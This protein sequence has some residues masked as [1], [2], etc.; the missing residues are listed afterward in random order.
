MRP[1]SLLGVIVRS[2]EALIY[3]LER[4]QNS[5]R[6]CYSWNRGKEHLRTFCERTSNTEIQRL[7]MVRNDRREGLR[8]NE[9]DIRF[10]RSTVSTEQGGTMG[11]RYA[12][13]RSHHRGV[14]GCCR[15]SRLI[16]RATLQM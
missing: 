8:G 5:L 13:S 10:A 11:W 16:T 1:P 12:S 7:V 9:F 15:S 4:H 3:A 6:G 14:L 2:T